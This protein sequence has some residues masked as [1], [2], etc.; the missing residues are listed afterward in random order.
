MPIPDEYQEVVGMLV[1]LTEQ[2]EL[3]WTMGETRFIVSTSIKG[4]G[5]KIEDSGIGA[6]TDFDLTLTDAHGDSIDSF[7]L[8]DVEELGGQDFNIISKMF[9]Q[10]VRQATGVDEKLTKLAADLRELA[11]D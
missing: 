5:V 8:N 9:Q 3:V 10:A 6:G 4:T 7:T 11:G 2:K 1:R